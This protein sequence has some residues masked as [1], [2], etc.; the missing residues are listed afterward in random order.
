MAA[1]KRYPRSFLQL[2]TLGHILVVLPLLVVTAYV[3]IT[4]DKLG[5][6]YRDAVHNS[7]AA[8]RL[9]GDITEDLQHMERNLR[10]YELLRDTDSLRD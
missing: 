2:V 7:F 4:L 6:Q 3:F 10:R 5:G 9:I 8:S 1:M